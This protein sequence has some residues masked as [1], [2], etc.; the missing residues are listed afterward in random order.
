[1]T[2]W[3]QQTEEIFK[4]WT[5]TQKKIMDNWAETVKGMSGSQQ[6]DIWQTSLVAWKDMLHKTIAAEAK[7]TQ[8]WLEQ[9]QSIDGMP[10][11]AREAT[12]QF[13]Q[14]SQRWAATQEQLWESWFEMLGSMDPARYSTRWLEA[15]QNPMQ[16]WQKATQQVVDAQAEWLKTWMGSAKRPA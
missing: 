11:E 6:A 4:A 5:E 7:W 1:M 10:A 14:L 13:Q 2:T 8:S 3:S 16:A 12:A 9:L 15:L